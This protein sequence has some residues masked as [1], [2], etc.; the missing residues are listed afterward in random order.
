MWAASKEALGQRKAEGWG[1]TL[2]DRGKVSAGRQWEDSRRMKWRLKE[3][4][5]RDEEWG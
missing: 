3:I 2:R 5:G 1:G 4:W